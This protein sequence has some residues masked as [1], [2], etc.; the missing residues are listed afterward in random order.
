MISSV[1]L[2]SLIA[3]L[4][5]YMNIT[6]LDDQLSILATMRFDMIGDSACRY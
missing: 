5:E 2:T 3:E 1:E 4:V 6:V